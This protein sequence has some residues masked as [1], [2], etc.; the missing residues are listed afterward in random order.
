MSSIKVAF[1][2]TILIV[3]GAMLGS[4]AQAQNYN[5][6]AYA[7]SPDHPKTWVDGATRTHQELRWSDEKHMLV[8]DVVYS[9]ADFADGPHPTQEDDFTLTFPT[10]HFDPASGKFTAN[11]VVVA[12]LHGGLF[13]HEVALDPKVDLSIHRHHGVVYGALIAHEE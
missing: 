11:G 9:T 13:G 1:F 6:Y 8:A 5:A 7:K 4:S 3:M 12:R 2:L 10:V